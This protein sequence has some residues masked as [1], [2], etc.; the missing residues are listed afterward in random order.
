MGREPEHDSSDVRETNRLDPEPRFDALAHSSS[1]GIIIHRQLRPL[2]ANQSFADLFGFERPEDVLALPSLE[3]LFDDHVAEWIRETATARLRGEPVRSVYELDALRRDGSALILQT[4]SSAVTW[5]GEQAVMAH[6]FDITERKRGEAIALENERLLRTVVANCPVIL[7][8]IDADGIVTFAEGRGLSSQKLESAD[9]VG[10]SIFEIYADSTGFLDNVRRALG[11]ESFTAVNETFGAVYERMFQPVL[12]DDGEVT[13]VTGVSVDITRSARA[14]ERANESERLLRSVID[15]LPH[16]VFLKDRALRY[17]LV[18]ESFARYHGMST[19]EMT[20][21]HG[22]QL[23]RR[24]QENRTLFA[25]DDRRVLDRGVTVHR[26]GYKARTP[27]GALADFDAIKIPLKDDTGA[28]VGVVGVVDNITE[29]RRAQRE[30]ERYREHLEELV[31][32]RTAELVSAQDELMR[33]ERLAAIGQLT[34]TVSH[35]LRNPL[36]TIRTSFQALRPGIEL[37]DDERTRRAVE[38]I[39]RSIDRCVSIIEELL[40]YTRAR[41]LKLE[42]VD[43]DDWLPRALSDIEPPEGVRLEVS[44]SSRARVRIDSNRIHQALVNLAQ[45]A[46][47]SL[48]ENATGSAPRVVISTSCD[49]DRVAVHV[50]DSGPGVAPDVRARIFEPLFS[51]RAFGVGLGLP[52]VRSIAEQHGGAVTYGAPGAP[53]GSTFT[54]HLPLA[55]GSR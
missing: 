47:Q 25:E 9:V 3:V 4:V 11:G 26:N 55:N 24:T 36:G 53:E 45:N 34:A 50:H 48:A 23:H 14:E 1:Q 17:Q 29:A 33:A 30:L 16:F 49:E 35:E 28:V 31:E 13:G 19:A 8:S 18:N 15:V 40:D 51:T 32:A 54:L 52:L 20:G 38:R 5:R 21:L 42:T 12:G 6:V 44:P 7:W 37:A 41:A 22:D 27:D 39:E 46:F 10:R 2:F 43:L